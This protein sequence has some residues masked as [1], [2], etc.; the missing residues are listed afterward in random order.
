MLL[1]TA[2]RITTKPLL[3]FISRVGVA[4]ISSLEVKGGIAA[5]YFCDNKYKLLLF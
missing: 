3:Q 4:Y 2:Y 1:P 5:N